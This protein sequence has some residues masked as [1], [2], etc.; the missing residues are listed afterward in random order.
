MAAALTLMRHGCYRGQG[1]L[2][3]Q[4]VAADA[5]ASLLSA[6]RLPMTFFDHD[7][8]FDAARD[9]VRQQ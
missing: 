5:M 3:S 9:L 1:F 7:K 8:A 4:P 2:L 6:G